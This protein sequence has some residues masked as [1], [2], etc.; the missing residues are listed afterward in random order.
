LEWCGREERVLVTHDV[1]TIIGFAKDCV[2]QHE[3]MPG[4]VVVAQTLPIGQA[5]DDL[6]LLADCSREGEWEGQVIYFPL[7]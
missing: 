2:T 4:I 6:V 3:S 7:R 1:R 5:I